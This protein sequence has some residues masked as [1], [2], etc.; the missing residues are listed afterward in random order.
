MKLCTWFSMKVVFGKGWIVFKSRR[1][2]FWN[3]TDFVFDVLCIWNR[4]YRCNFYIFERTKV[5]G[6][7]FNG[8]IIRGHCTN[9][10]IAIR[11]KEKQNTAMK[12]EIFISHIF[13]L[14]F[15]SFSKYTF[16]SKDEN[17]LSGYDMN[18]VFSFFIF[19]VT[20]GLQP[21]VVRCPRRL[22]RMKYIK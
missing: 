11:T 21:I 22:K 16:D 15:S 17:Q 12:Y 14:T 18:Y 7:K 10:Y 5:F 9:V 19:D 13:F 1:S 2:L 8:N 3:H 6:R 20:W 4:I